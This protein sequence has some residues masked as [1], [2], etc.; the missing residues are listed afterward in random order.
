[1][2]VP[3]AIPAGRAVT[4]FV[5]VCRRLTPESE[6]ANRVVTLMVDEMF[7]KGD[8]KQRKADIESFNAVRSAIGRT[9]AT[10]LDTVNFQLM[11]VLKKTVPHTYFVTVK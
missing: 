1:M 6:D 11:H 10:D 2:D 7:D 4:L 5:S 9:C 3:S 8:I